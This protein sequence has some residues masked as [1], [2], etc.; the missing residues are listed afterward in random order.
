ML[1]PQPV[2]PASSLASQEKRVTSSEV[3]SAKTAMNSKEQ[4]RQLACVVLCSVAKCKCC[5]TEAEL[6]HLENRQANA[7]RHANKR[8]FG[9]SNVNEKNKRINFMN[10]YKNVSSAP[11]NQKVNIA[12]A[13]PRDGFVV[14]PLCLNWA[15]AFD[16]MTHYACNGLYICYDTMNASQCSLMIHHVCM[17]VLITSSSPSPAQSSFCCP[18]FLFQSKLTHMSCQCCCI[19]VP[20]LQSPATAVAPYQ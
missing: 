11:D 9:M 15:A 20:W 8:G 5:R 10:A 7:E 3:L 18:L 6:S 1:C 19:A 13:T 2:V 4:Q 16:S 12:S 14:P 17:C